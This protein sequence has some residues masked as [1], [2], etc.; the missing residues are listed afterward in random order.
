MLTPP[1]QSWTR[2][3]E[4]PTLEK[5][6]WSVLDNECDGSSQFYYEY[7][8]DESFVINQKTCHLSKFAK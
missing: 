3:D 7:T 1:Y 4:C 6:R 5:A 2:Y 8:N